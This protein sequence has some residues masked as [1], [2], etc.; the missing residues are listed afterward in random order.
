M[1]LY[2][3]INL[4][5]V[6][7]TIYKGSLIILKRIKKYGLYSLLGETIGDFAASIS[8]HDKMTTCCGINDLVK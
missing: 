2:T 3:H 4:K 1:M 6:Y 7:L 5:N 8:K